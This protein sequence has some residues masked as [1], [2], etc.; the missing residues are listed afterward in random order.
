MKILFRADASTRMG[1]GHVS[2][3]ATLGHELQRRG[4]TV[5]FV[6]RAARGNYIAWLRS[7]G[8]DV[9]SLACE[10]PQSG[11]ADEYADW[12][13]APVA[14]EIE[15]MSALLEQQGRV[16]WL[17]VDHYAIDA[18]WERALK[19][20]V[21]N[22]LCIDD[23]ANR[24]H[25]CDLLLDQNLYVAPEQRYTDLLP[26]TA[27]TLLGPC[28][29]LLRPEF[30]AGRQHLRARDGAVRRIFLFMGGG[31]SANVTA[32]VLDA[33]A[34]SKHADVA[35]DVVVG[36]ANSHIADIQVRYA[37][38][39]NATLHK[40]VD[41]L[42]ELMTQADL[43]IGAAGVSTWERAALGLPSLTVSVADNQRDIARYADEAGLLTWLGDS[44]DVSVPEWIRRIDIACGSA[45]ILRRQSQAC[46]DLV[47]A[48]G[49]QRVVEVML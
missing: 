12:L 42:A 10:S 45:D 5:S 23:L 31:D 28:Y 16:D 8:F 48:N 18:R 44:E 14:Q 13:G 21:G 40:Q 47:D 49:A 32:T 6:C 26:A 24:A 38:L 41:N 15:S 19:H 46:L 43:A 4:A 17:V 39:P 34:Q 30:A 9:E 22:T 1:A 33:L 37:R 2:R 20:R 11:G 36:G 35:V 3:C 25:D 27:K 7:A 29:A